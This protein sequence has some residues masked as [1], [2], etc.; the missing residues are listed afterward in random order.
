MS[1]ALKTAITETLA[2]LEAAAANRVRQA[3]ILDL[4]QSELRG[5]VAFIDLEIEA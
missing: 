5:D 2:A 4:I 1:N 3:R